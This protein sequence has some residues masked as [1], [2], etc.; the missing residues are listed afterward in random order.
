MS[1]AYRCGAA[2]RAD[3]AWRLDREGDAVVS[4]ACHPH[5]VRVLLSLQ[6]ADNTVIRVR[7]HHRPVPG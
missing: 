4:W 2:C 7:M 3:P 6:R 5:L 1:A